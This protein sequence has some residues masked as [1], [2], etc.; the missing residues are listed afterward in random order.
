M[1]PK[2]YFH[3]ALVCACAVLLVFTI[4]KTHLASSSVSEWVALTILI[5]LGI[6]AQHIAT[7][8]PIAGSGSRA[9]YASLLFIPMF[10]CAVAFPPIATVVAI[11]V[12][13]VAVELR[14]PRIY[15]RIIFNVS[16]HII[17]YGLAA[18]TYHWLAGVTPWATGVDIIAFYAMVVVALGSNQ[19]LVGQFVACRHDEQLATVLRR[20]VGPGGGNL[21]YDLLASPF[22][23]FV[24][25]LYGELGPLGPLLVILPILF[26][27]Y[28]YQDSQRLQQANKDLLFVLVKTIE[29]RD[30]YTS[31]H[32]VRVATLS[33]AI[34]EDMKLP[35]RAVASIETAATLHDV[36]KIDPV[37]AP[38]IKKPFALT[39]E[40]MKL[41]QTHSARGAEIL[42]ALTSLPNEVV[43]AVR[44]HHERVDGN[45][46]PDGLRGDEI[47]LAARIIMTADSID[48]MLSDRPYRAA[49]TIAKVKAE[50]LRCSGTQFDAIIAKVVAEN[51]TLE[52]AAAL[53]SL[54]VREQSKEFPVQVA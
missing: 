15:W 42:S 31:G 49:L 48:A 37:Y 16:Q 7:E 2:A 18:V 13:Q 4:D 25:F 10:A 22:A 24:V 8:F 23:I 46:Y 41:I 5:A 44:H 35:A 32:S 51:D 20:T 33:R 1:S 21:Y 14:L 9:A 53:A 26:F 39:P 12:V 19:L 45:G 40:E 43:L 28:S 36:G 17:T 54:A 6:L 52:R 50:L 30:P 27:R 38:L 29:M 11:F 47:P 3:I 34:A